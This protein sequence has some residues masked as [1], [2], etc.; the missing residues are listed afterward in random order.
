MA[1]RVEHQQGADGV[2]HQHGLQ[3]RLAWLTRALRAYLIGYGEFL[4]Q[5][6]DHGGGLRSG[7]GGEGGFSHIDIQ[8]WRM[9]PEV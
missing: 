9:C 5:L 6:H 4:Q 8:R 2:V 1:T 7:V 3:A